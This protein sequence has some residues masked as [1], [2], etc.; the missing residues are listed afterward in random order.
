MEEWT[1]ASCLLTLTLTSKPSGI[2]LLVLEA[3]SSR[4]QQRVG[5]SSSL[6]TLWESRIRLGLQIHAITWTE[7]LSDPWLFQQ[8]ASIGEL[9]R[10]QPITSLI[11]F[12]YIIYIH[13]SEMGLHTLLLLIKKI[14]PQNNLVESVPLLRFSLPD[15]STFVSTNKNQRRQFPNVV[16][17][18]GL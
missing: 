15:M 6:G 17:E 1:F 9:L 10:P 12:I 13:I 4:F 11:N 5:I 16:E 14:S 7:Q 2:C 8:E 3:T 18:F